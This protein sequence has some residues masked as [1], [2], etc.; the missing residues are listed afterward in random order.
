MIDSTRRWVRAVVAAG[1]VLLAAACAPPAHLQGDEAAAGADEGVLRVGLLLPLTGT[2]AGPGEDM[3]RG[4]ELYW[5]RNPTEVA[6]T[7][8][9]SLIEDSAGTPA[10]ALTRAERLADDEGA[11]VFVGELLTN[12]SVAL[13]DYV[14]RR[15]LPILQPVQSAPEIGDAVE[16]SDNSLLVRLGPG[17]MSIARPAARW[18]VEHGHRRAVSFCP[19]YEFGYESCGGFTAGLREQGGEVLGELFSPLGTQD[20]STYI[21]QIQQLDPDA[22]FVGH[23]GGDAIRFVQAWSD[24]GLKDRI[25][26]IGGSSVLDQAVLRSMGESAEGLL[27]VSYYAEGDDRSGTAD[28]VTTY[29]QEY[30]ELPSLFAASMYTTAQWLALAVAQQPPGPRDGAALV[31]AMRAISW[32]S[33]FGRLE[34]DPELSAV[35]SALLRRVERRDDGVLWNVL[36]EDMGRVR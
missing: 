11:D 30:G 1:G 12:V 8:I 21:A 16:R 36:V 27:S 18:A 25:P 13:G 15:G 28:F 24:F 32:D 26:L 22:V 14:T 17:D 3:R 2:M 19:D 35:Y 31:A 5:K 34:L 6:G 33:P 23:T 4:W 9:E 20:F 29:Q 7:R 10:T